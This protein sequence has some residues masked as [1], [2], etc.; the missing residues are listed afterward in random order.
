MITVSLGTRLP[1]TEQARCAGQTWFT[2]D[3]TVPQQLA[4]CHRCPVSVECAAY[5][6]QHEPVFDDI[7]WGAMLPQ[8]LADLKKQLRP[9]KAVR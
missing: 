3:L 8:D 7:V 4:I 5:A 6:L 9:L 2:E 1:W